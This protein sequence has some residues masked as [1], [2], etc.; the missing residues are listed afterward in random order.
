V[1]GKKVVAATLRDVVVRPLTEED[2]I[3][4]DE[5]RYTK[6]TKNGLSKADGLSPMEREELRYAVPLNP[7]DL[8]VFS[9][10]QMYED[11]FRYAAKIKRVEASLT[12]GYNLRSLEISIRQGL[13]PVRRE[14]KS[15]SLAWADLKRIGFKTIAN[16]T[17][18]M[19]VEPFKKQIA[20]VSIATAVATAQPDNAVTADQIEMRINQAP[21]VVK[22]TEQPVAVKPDEVIKASKKDIRPIDQ[23]T[24]IA[25]PASFLLLPSGG[26]IETVETKLHALNPMLEN[27]EVTNNYGLVLLASPGISDGTFRS[28]ASPFLEELYREGVI[29]TLPEHTIATIEKLAAQL[30]NGRYHTISMF[31]LYNVTRDIATGLAMD[32]TG[33]NV[34]CAWLQRPGNGSPVGEIVG[35]PIRMDTPENTDFLLMAAQDVFNGDQMLSK[36]EVP[37]LLQYVI[38]T[39]YVPVTDGH[40]DTVGQVGFSNFYSADE[41]GGKMLLPV[42][43]S[44]TS[45][46]VAGNEVTKHGQSAK[47]PFLSAASSTPNSTTN[48]SGL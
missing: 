15:A 45:I 29:K 39:R 27:L 44:S 41:L 7:V 4:L 19:L 25:V 38:A 1:Y 13:E 30:D 43:K 46:V 21:E 26:K 5:F 47:V 23:S 31:P 18:A 3:K 33:E 40:G 36:D 16:N 20:N 8:I 24:E 14:V 12:K 17:A 2:R 10:E 9:D 11:D 22:A 34:P 6:Q 37:P 28:I 42:G 48:K 32:L 35:A